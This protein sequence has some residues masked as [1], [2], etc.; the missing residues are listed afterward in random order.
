VTIIFW[1]NRETVLSI[2]K[3][4]RQERGRQEVERS[5]SH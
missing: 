2:L 5:F 4:E 1:H 3:S